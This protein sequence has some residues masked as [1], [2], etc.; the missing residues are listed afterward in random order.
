L[1]GS[2]QVRWWTWYVFHPGP[3]SEHLV[4]WT[5]TSMV[6]H[7]SETESPITLIRMNATSIASVRWCATHN[8]EFQRRSIALRSDWRQEFW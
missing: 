4:W 6:H 7:F 5:R 2:L 8:V 1:Q 3:D